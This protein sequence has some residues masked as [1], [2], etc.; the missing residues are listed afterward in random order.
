MNFSPDCLVDVRADV[1]AGV[2]G[3]VVRQGVEGAVVAGRDTVLVV[4]EGIADRLGVSLYVGGCGA[5]QG[6][7]E[8][9]GLID[10]AVVVG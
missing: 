8:Q 7:G 9:F 10:D 6:L 2:V 1:D 5:G 4:G 3:E